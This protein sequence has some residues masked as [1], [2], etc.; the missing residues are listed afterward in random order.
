MRGG[1]LDWVDLQSFVLAARHGSL[2]EAAARLGVPKSTVSRRV[3]RLEHALGAGLLSRTANAIRLTDAGERLFEQCA[4]ALEQLEQAEATFE[5][6]AGR[7]A[8]TLRV[9]M[10]EDF[11]QSTPLTRL[12]L[13]FQDRFPEVEVEVVATHRLV[14]LVGEG[15]DA[16]LRPYRGAPGWAADGSLRMR[17]LGELGGGLYAAPALARALSGAPPEALAA[18]VRVAHTQQSGPLE[19]ET[20]EGP[21]A[22]VVAPRLRATSMSVLAEAGRLGASV[23]SLPRFLGDPLVERG[24][25]VPVRPDWS[26][27]GA[28]LA[29]V[30]PAARLLA[31]RLRAFVDFCAE[32]AATLGVVQP[33]RGDVAIGERAR[34]P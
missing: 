20:P 17:V 5:G 12:L 7:V 4:P 33:L 16:A 26:I 19:V 24:E 30:W 11:G 1:N 21:R 22:L 18:A 8:G 31:P 14:D 10:P 3:R 23:V 9:T 15:V 28:R 6:V 2:T 29:L 27:A 13:T 32:H 25:L 34:R